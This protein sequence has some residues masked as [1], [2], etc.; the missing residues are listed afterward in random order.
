MLA[1][2]IQPF[3]GAILEGWQLKVSA[4]LLDREGFGVLS[5]CFPR[6]LTT[7]YLFPPAGEREN[8]VKIHSLWKC[9]ERISFGKSER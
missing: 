2:P 6:I 3:K 7:T 8:A 4:Q 5:F 1:G 9:L